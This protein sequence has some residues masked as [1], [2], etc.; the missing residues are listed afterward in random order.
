MHE[1][2]LSPQGHV[3]FLFSCFLPLS[4]PNSLGVVV[5]WGKGVPSLFPC[6]VGTAVGVQLL[7]DPCLLVFLPCAAWAPWLPSPSPAHPLQFAAA[8]GSWLSPRFWPCSFLPSWQLLNAFKEIANQ[9]KAKYLTQVAPPC[10]HCLCL[11]TREGWVWKTLPSL[12][13]EVLLHVLVSYAPIKRFWS[14]WAPFSL[15]Y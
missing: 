5:G 4:L 11:P 2:H 14:F 9:K 1:G 7:W 13:V 10:L 8:L 6:L 3:L 12:G 15:I